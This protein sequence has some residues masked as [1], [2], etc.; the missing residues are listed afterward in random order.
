[1]N[2]HEYERSIEFPVCLHPQYFGSNSSIRHFSHLS[3]SMRHPPYSPSFMLAWSIRPS[4]QSV[5]HPWSPLLQAPVPSRSFPHRLLLRPLPFR[6]LFPPS[7]FTAPLPTSRTYAHK[8]IQPMSVD[9]GRINPYGRSPATARRGRIR[10][11]SGLSLDKADAQFIEQVKRQENDHQRKGIP[12]RGN[13]GR[14]EQ[15]YDDGMPAV[16]PQE[17]FGHKA[18]FREQPRQ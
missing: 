8:T 7:I 18:H 16:F 15:Q 4:G 12:R 9:I 13:D 10:M 5:S 14:K 3:R 6:L 2:G 11:E 1:M 17:F